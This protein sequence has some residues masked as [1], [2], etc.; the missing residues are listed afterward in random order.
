M[1]LRRYMYCDECR[2]GLDDAEVQEHAYES[3]HIHFTYRGRTRKDD[4]A[5]AARE[6]N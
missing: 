6:D 4:E 3:G 1:K 5:E 2:E